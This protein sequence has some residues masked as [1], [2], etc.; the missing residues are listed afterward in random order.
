MEAGKRIRED[1][2][3]DMRQDTLELQK[4]LLRVLRMSNEREEGSKV[5]WLVGCEYCGLHV[6]GPAS[7]LACS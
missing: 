2:P 3:S 6:D 4:T 1:T 5:E 7:R